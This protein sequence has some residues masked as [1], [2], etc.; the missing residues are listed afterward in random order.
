MLDKDII[1]ISTYQ[2]QKLLMKVVIGSRNAIP[3]TQA[4]LDGKSHP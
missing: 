3:L 1:I 4:N 2:T